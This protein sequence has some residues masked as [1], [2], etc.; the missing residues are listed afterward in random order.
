MARDVPPTSS[1]TATA[2]EVLDRA[3]RALAPPEDANPLVPRVA[4]GEAPREVFA[5]F[6]LEQHHIIPA[7]RRSFAHLA[8]RAAGD[9]PIDDFFSFLAEG[10]TLALGH[11]RALAAACELSERAVA[12]YE[13]LAGCQSYPAYVAWLALNAEPADAVV[14]VA[15]NFAA[16][17]G[18]CGAM[19]RAMRR[20]YA[21]AEEAV[22]FFDLFAEPSPELDRLTRAAVRHGL[23]AGAVTPESAHR[24]GRLLQ[25]YEIMFWTTLAER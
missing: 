9:P 14:A 2:T 22:A 6:A 21:F 17:G 3:V 24:Y 12:G 8:E 10:E 11:L 15:A 5:L 4:A 7:D 16:W 23:D 25:S 19:A 1:A 20:H 18:Y 13:P